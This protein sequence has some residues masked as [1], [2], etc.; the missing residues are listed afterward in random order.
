MA[1]NNY[2]CSIIRVCLG[3]DRMPDRNL[4]YWAHVMTV[5]VKRE[6]RIYWCNFVLL[7]TRIIAGPKK[8][9]S[10]QETSNTVP[11]L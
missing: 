3:E 2:D 10:L 1:T 9:Q 8:V 11:N 4:L 5:S 6:A 7:E